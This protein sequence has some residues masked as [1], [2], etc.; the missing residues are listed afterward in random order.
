MIVRMAKDRNFFPTTFTP[1]E[2]GII[3]GL[4]PSAQQN[5]RRRNYLL[6]GPAGAWSR[7]D[8]PATAGMQIY[9]KASALRIP[10]KTAK[11][12]LANAKNAAI[13]I[14]GHAQECEG[15]IHNPNNL[16]MRPKRPINFGPTTLYRFMISYGTDTDAEVSFQNDIGEFYSKNWKVD[17]SAAIVFDLARLAE[18]LCARAGR[19]LWTALEVK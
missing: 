16:T 18:Q 1:G 2:A 3:T 9:G 4:S 19:P 5:M 7:F 15:A 17:L 13:F 6:P 10:P 11:K 8:L 12:I 14:L